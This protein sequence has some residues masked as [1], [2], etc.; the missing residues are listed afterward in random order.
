[1]FTRS[2]VETRLAEPS[3]ASALLYLSSSR[4]S[5]VCLCLRASGYSKC[6]VRSMRQGEEGAA[7]AGFVLRD[8]GTLVCWPLNYAVRCGYISG[9]RFFFRSP[10]LP[11]V[12]QT[13]SQNA[14][15]KSLLVAM[16]SLLAFHLWSLR[17]CAFSLGQNTLHEYFSRIFV[18][19]K[20][21]HGFD[22]G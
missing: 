4:C 22:L 3:F 6:S 10:P 15:V 9:N 11:H 12:T 13:A 7:G 1:M 18:I 8:L 19:L 14:R 16:V 17:V 2:S 21:F 20:T 5:G